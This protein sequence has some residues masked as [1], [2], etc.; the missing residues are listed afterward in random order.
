MNGNIKYSFIAILFTTLISACSNKISQLTGPIEPTPSVNFYAT[1]DSIAISDQAVLALA[2]SSNKYP[3]G[4]YQENLDDG[5]IYYV[6]TL[7]ILPLEQRTSNSSELSTNNR[8]TALAWSESS[9]ANGLNYRKMTSESETN[10]YFQFRFKGMNVKD[11]VLYRVHKLSYVDRSMYDSFHP[12]SYIAKLNF[13]AIDTTSVQEFAEYI[14]FVWHYNIA[15]AQAIAVVNKESADTAWCV[16]YTLSKVGGDFR[17]NDKITINRSI[18]S[19]SRHT[20]DVI[21]SNTAERTINGK[22]N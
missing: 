14:W 10:K 5:S 21:F 1:F 9:E 12:T 2:Y 17:L 16:L 4:F 19:V 6:N 22:L 3:A 20:G 13:R 7:S 11:I 8:D 15:G 18:Y